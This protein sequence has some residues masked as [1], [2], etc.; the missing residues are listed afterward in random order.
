VFVFICVCVCAAWCVCAAVGSTEVGGAR[1][2]KLGLPVCA[3]RPNFLLYEDAATYLHRR[4][5]THSKLWLGDFIRDPKGFSIL[6]RAALV[7]A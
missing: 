2:E 7:C 6:S 1:L 5:G 4:V 3:N